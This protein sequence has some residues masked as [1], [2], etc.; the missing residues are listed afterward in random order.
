MA[1][2]NTLR[3]KK[4][5]TSG[6]SA[7]DLKK[8]FDKLL[9]AYGPQHWWP[10]DTATE[11]IVGA[12]LTQN[13][14]W[15][16]VEKAIQ[17]LREHALLNWVRLREIPVERLAELIRP[18]GYYN[19]KARRLKHFVQ[20]L[21][22]KHG[23]RLDVLGEIPLSQLREELLSVNGIGPETADSILLYAL[24]R[25]SFVVDAYTTRILQR[26]Y[27][28]GE[29]AKYEEIKQ[30]FECALP[31][32]VE[33]FNEFHALIVALAKRHCRKTPDCD[34]CPLAEFPHMA[35]R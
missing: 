30:V 32:D 7:K 3:G 14:N 5:P 18:A 29:D 24:N 19:V 11:I 13:T 16:N 34:G 35:A 27:L 25:P 12:I 28:I 1:R 17:N 20:W 9:A 21:W 15:K 8:Y 26:H 31:H 22:E 4:H 23:G 10:G 33:L 2:S 6:A